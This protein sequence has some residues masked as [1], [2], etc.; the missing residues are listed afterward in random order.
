[1]RRYKKSPLLHDPRH[2]SSFQCPV[3]LKALISLLNHEFQI[4]F[5]FRRRFGSCVDLRFRRP[6]K[7]GQEGQEGDPSTQASS[8]TVTVEDQQVRHRVGRREEGMCEGQSGQEGGL[9]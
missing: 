7:Q 5:R 3:D 4:P 2:I 6:T 8:E 9:G 1:M